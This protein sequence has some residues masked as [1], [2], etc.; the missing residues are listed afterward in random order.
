VSM[1]VPRLLRRS[2]PGSCATLTLVVP[3]MSLQ[4]LSSEHAALA[5]WKWPACVSRTHVSSKS[6]R[7]GNAHRRM[8]SSEANEKDSVL[9]GRTRAIFTV[10]K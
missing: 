8:Y 1:T 7:R 10:N 5:P 4:A 6:A 9:L 2:H 3:G